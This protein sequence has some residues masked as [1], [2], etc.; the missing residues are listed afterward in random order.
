MLI[1]LRTIWE[2]WNTFK[3]SEWISLESDFI[4]MTVFADKLSDE[5][6]E[7]LNRVTKH[8]MDIRGFLNE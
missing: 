5:K 1:R 6:L 3:S 8:E 7:L 4:D 2:N